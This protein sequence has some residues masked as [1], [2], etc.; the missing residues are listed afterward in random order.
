MCKIVLGAVWDHEIRNG[1]NLAI[2]AQPS[3]KVPA[4]RIRCWYSL[5]ALEIR[6]SDLE[7]APDVPPGLSGNVQQ[8]IS[9]NASQ[10]VDSILPRLARPF[11]YEKK[12]R[13]VQADEFFGRE[14]TSY[15]LRMG[16]SG[17]HPVLLAAKRFEL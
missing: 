3:G 16:L 12:L 9:T 8:W 14:G 13:G 15:R 7:G 6:S 4:I 11:V 17:G 10:F 2:L 5:N 1:A